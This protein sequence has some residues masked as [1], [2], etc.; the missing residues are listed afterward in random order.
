MIK[1]RLSFQIKMLPRTDW[2]IIQVHKILFDM[3]INS[4][5]YADAR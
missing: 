2:L 1:S 3:K 4:E 5:I